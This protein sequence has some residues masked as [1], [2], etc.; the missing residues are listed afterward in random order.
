MVWINPMD[1]FYNPIQYSWILTG[2]ESEITYTFDGVW[3]GSDLCKL[4]AEN[5]FSE[6][7]W[8][9]NTQFR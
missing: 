4:Y 7:G 2:L 5:R 9:D 6:L 8:H 3:I 1:F